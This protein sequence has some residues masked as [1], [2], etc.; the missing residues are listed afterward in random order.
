M[1][2]QTPGERWHEERAP[3]DERT[4]FLI[5]L[6]VCFL[7]FI[8]MAGWHFFGKQNPS[9]ITYKVSPQEFL[10][11]YNAFVEKCKIGEKNGIPVVK[12][13]PESDVFLLARMWQWRPILI[14][15]KGKWYTFHISSI[16]LQHGFSLQPVNMNFQV[17]PNYDYVLRFK[18]TKKGEHSI[19]CN[20]FCG[21]GHHLMI[22]KIVV[23]GEGET[24]EDYGF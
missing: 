9:P 6:A 8:W 19:I 2:L 21:I 14:L 1:A 18:P 3:R 5:S 13:P 23:L 12:P 22:G 24:P 15:E 11:L 4:W 10:E 17:V 16:D 20:E 7:F